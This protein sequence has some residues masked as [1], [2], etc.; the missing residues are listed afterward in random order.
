M[1][2]TVRVALAGTA[3][4]LLAACSDS[5]GP[6]AA[7]SSSPSAS[8]TLSAADEQSIKDAFLVFFDPRST[9]QQVAA[10]VQHGTSF[11]REITA[12]ASS[13]YSS[14]SGV[15]VTSVRARSATVA[16]VTFTVTVG[17]QPMLPDVPGYAVR[18]HGTWTMAAKT[19]CDLLALDGTKPAA[20]SD[21]SVTD[22]PQ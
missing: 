8:G 1:R 2:M 22:L 19:F 12:L 3:L 11:V 17:G 20:C 15:K 4:L 6:T 10:K 7:G 14:S 9:A 18:E 21:P 16:D 5:N 13:Q